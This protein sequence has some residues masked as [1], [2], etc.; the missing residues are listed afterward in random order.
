MYYI[1]GT[2]DALEISGNAPGRIRFSLIPASER[3]ISRDE[4][5]KMAL[6][7]DSASSAALLVEVGKNAAGR[8][9]LWFHAEEHLCNILLSAK[10]T[11]NTIRT[12]CENPENTDPGDKEPIPPIS[13][14]KAEGI[15]VF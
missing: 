1:E 8:E 11:R 10:N 6:F 3:I 5:K 12:W 14:L 9:V 7:T 4:G 13:T 15:R 2:V